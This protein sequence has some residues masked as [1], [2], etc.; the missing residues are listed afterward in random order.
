[1]RGICGWV[2]SARRVRLISYQSSYMSIRN[3]HNHINPTII[4]QP[5]R[6]VRH[7]HAFVF[8]QF[9]IRMVGVRAI[10]THLH[11]LIFSSSVKA[12]SAADKPMKVTTDLWCKSSRTRAYVSRSSTLLLSCIF[13]FGL[14]G[15]TH[16]TS[17]QG[18]R[19][20]RVVFRVC[21]FFKV[22]PSIHPRKITVILVSSAWNYVRIYCCAGNKNNRNFSSSLR[23]GVRR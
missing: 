2:G 11:I 15:N 9:G 23:C 20:N 13:F 22:L 1:M 16:T 4:N 8:T 3:H 6:P 18:R 12:P 7:K 21:V 10:R 19:K 17:C 5:I 14:D